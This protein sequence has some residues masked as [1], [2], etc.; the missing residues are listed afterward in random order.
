MFM[1]YE[2][3]Y[4]ILRI[5]LNCKTCARWFHLVVQYICVCV[6]MCMCMLDNM[7]TYTYTYIHTCVQT[8]TWN[9]KLFAFIIFPHISLQV[10]IIFFL[11]HLV[12]G[13]VWPKSFLQVRVSGVFPRQGFWQLLC[14]SCGSSSRWQA[15]HNYNVLLRDSSFWH[16]YRPW[17]LL[18]PPPPFLP[19]A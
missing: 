13:C 17:T 12:Y 9:L 2:N 15:Q 14:F 19:L 18:T 5:K 3:I 7:H 6:C 8:E 10:R 1:L 16:S 4:G 11:F